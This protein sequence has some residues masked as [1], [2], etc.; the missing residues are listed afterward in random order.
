MI[1][2]RSYFIITYGCTFNQGDSL[3]IEKIFED[4]GIKKKKLISADIVVINTCAVKLSTESKILYYISNLV[5]KF[6]SKYY[7]ITG[8]LPQIDK[9]IFNKIESMI[10]KKG[11][12][13][14]IQDI[15]NLL[16]ILFKNETFNQK[17]PDYKEKS[18][19]IPHINRKSPISIIQI[20]EGCNNNCSYCCTTNARGKL[21]SFDSKLIIRQ[22]EILIS[23]GIKEFHIT[24]QDLGNY[25]FEGKKLHHLLKEISNLDGNLHFRLGM[26]NPDYLKK[27]YSEFQEIFND[28]RFYRFLHIPIQS[29]SNKILKKMK[30]H[31]IIEDVETIFLKLKKFDELFGIGTDVIIGFPSESDDDYALT[32][33][34]IKK[35][36]PNILNISKF[37]VRPNTEAKKY[38]Q[39][40][41]QIIKERSKKLS[42][43]FSDYSDNFN[44]QWEGWEGMVFYNEFRENAQ[45]SY[46]GRN[47][48]YIP[49]LNKN[50]VVGQNKNTKI[51]GYLNHSLIGL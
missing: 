28:K 18:I 27:F 34:F 10:S 25:D 39:L 45:F 46:M 12:I 40:N 50:A 21:H 24:S 48:Y 7:I 17:L 42:I 41:S 44:K 51:T 30:R 22:F 3:K 14:N 36:K 26:I 32:E 23:K 9:K 37:T 38:K 29:G 13:L 5:Q 47:L 20:S 1:N 2:L 16:N 8:C 15:P 49:V 4:Y 19:I 35:W 11:F 6:P 33:K 43:I 31:Y